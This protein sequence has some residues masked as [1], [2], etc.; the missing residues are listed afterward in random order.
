MP[1]CIPAFSANT[2]IRRAILITAGI[3]L[4]R[5]QAGAQVTSLRI[6]N[7]NI[8]SAD[9]S[10]DNNITGTGHTIP[11]IIEAMGMHHI[12]TVAQ[13]VDVLGLEELTSTSGENLV[14]QL[15]SYYGAGTYA[16]DPTTD[17]NTGGGPDGLLYDTH[18][19]QVVAAR[20]LPDG[21]NVVRQSNGTY[22]AAAG[23][24]AGGSVPRAPMLYQLRPVGYTAS[25]GADFYMYVSH[26]RSSS[27]T[28][29]GTAR[30]AE[31][32]ELRSDARYQLPANAHIIYSGDFNLFNGSG[33][34][35]YKCLTGQP[36]SDA[37]TWSDSTQGYD[38][39][40]KTSTTTTFSNAASDNANYLYDDS[41]TSLTSRLDVQLVSSS[42]L[43]SP[44]V[45]L[46][47]DTS[48]PYDTK[49]FPSSQYSHAF[50]VFGNNGTTPR[51]GGTNQAA[52]TSL[53]D[54]GSAASTI[55]SDLQQAGSGST[56]TGS[57]HLPIMADYVVD[58]PEPV[59]S[60]VLAIIPFL[61]L[62]SKRRVFIRF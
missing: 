37:L 34:N 42:M 49:N 54:L 21:T 25:S 19:V 18:T 45:Q 46:A 60:G 11:A 62:R 6:G 4:I 50:E 10:S 32:Q 1:I 43:S 36:T 31:A 7:Y 30:Y 3:L 55:L 58:V 38:P 44:G 51:S 22:A 17:P 53:S 16:F 13:P 27:D 12:G 5:S 29:T 47:S 14:T 61:L 56:S 9:Q 28:S 20:A 15:N 41:S 26:A 2:L 52:N 8:D 57:D 23:A 24:G 40:S 35:A 39:T 33:E 48:D 59:V